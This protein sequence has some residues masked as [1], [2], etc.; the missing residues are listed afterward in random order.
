MG[1][2]LF[3]SRRESRLLMVGLDSAGKTTILYRLKLGDT[4]TT[5][6]TVGFNVETVEYKKVKFCVW[7]VGGQDKIRAL[8]RHYFH[9]THAIVYVVDSSDRDR[10]EET[11]EELS[12]LLQER[13]LQN[14]VL[15]VFAN[16]QD[17]PNVISIREVGERIGLTTNTIKHNWHIQPCCAVTGA[18]L[19]EGLDWLANALEVARKTK[20]SKK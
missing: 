9:N 7:D 6:P 2:K 10:I 17:L 19:L 14:A 5:L 8:W 4:V 13:E 1:G 18:G 12:K 15:L 3:K 20:R 11:R 16:K